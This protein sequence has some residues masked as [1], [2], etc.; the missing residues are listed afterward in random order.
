MA[1]QN[2]R[3]R[4]TKWWMQ[5]VSLLIEIGALKIQRISSHF[6]SMLFILFHPPSLWV[7]Y[8]HLLIYRH[9]AHKTQYRSNST[10]YLLMLP[11]L[12]F[13]ELFKSDRRFCKIESNEIRSILIFTE[14]VFIFFW[15]TQIS[16]LPA[17]ARIFWIFEIH[18][19]SNYWYLKTPGII[20]QIL[21]YSP[22]KNCIP[23]T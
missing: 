15:L 2:V 6:L 21:E 7:I 20:K 8:G 22:Q 5:A 4:I 1:F 18:L 23:E 10:I 11:F 19:S 12:P 3:P 13:V 17:D 9:L 16:V 14:N